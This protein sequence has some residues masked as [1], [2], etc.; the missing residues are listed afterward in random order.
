MPSCEHAKAVKTVANAASEGCQQCIAEGQRWVELRVCLDCGHV[1]CCDSSPGR[2]AR[3]HF[4]QTGHAV[5]K[6]HSAGSWR[7]C[8]VHDAYV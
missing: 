7:W 3:Q 5:M 8:Y 6:P 2:H 1:G 4:Q